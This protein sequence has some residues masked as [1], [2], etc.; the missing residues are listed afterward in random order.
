[1][2]FFKNTQRYDLLVLCAKTLGK[3]KEN[4]TRANHNVETGFHHALALPLACRL[5]RRPAARGFCSAL[6]IPRWPSTLH[7][8]GSLGDSPP[9]SCHVVRQ[10]SASGMGRSSP[11]CG[12][13]TCA[14]SANP[15]LESA[16]V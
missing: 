7:P 6:A 9:D 12:M 5:L 3:P 14:A 16:I 13:P 2:F 1:M 11:V 4:A 15:S 8:M 10:E